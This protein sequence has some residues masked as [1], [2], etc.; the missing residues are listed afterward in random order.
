MYNIL[1]LVNR[2]AA[3]DKILRSPGLHQFVVHRAGLK[4]GQG[5]FNWSKA[6]V[7]VF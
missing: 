1:G 4:P 2:N 6:I 7:E 3:S 5:T